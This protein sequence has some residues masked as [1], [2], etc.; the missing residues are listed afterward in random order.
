MAEVELRQEAERIT[1][2]M[3]IGLY[4][5]DRAGACT[6]T[7]QRWQEIFGLSLE[8]SR[9]SGWA[10]TIHPEDRTAVFAE[11]TQAAAEAREFEMG[12]RLLRRDGSAINVHSQAKALRD[13]SGAITGFLGFVRM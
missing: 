13:P 7:N 12:F 5:T 3:P 11:W 10:D 6:F 1:S 2:G 8:E 9:G 4:A